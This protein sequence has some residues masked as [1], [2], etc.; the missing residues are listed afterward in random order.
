MERVESHRCQVAQL[1]SELEL[2]V[3]VLERA[4]SDAKK[5]EDNVDICIKY[6]T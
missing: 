4:L 1:E 2:G 6:L 5:N 3:K